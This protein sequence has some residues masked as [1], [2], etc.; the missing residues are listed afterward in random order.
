MLAAI[1]LVRRLGLAI[2]ALIL[3]GNLVALVPGSNRDHVS[4]V[5]L[6]AAILAF[7]LPAVE[8]SSF[9]SKQE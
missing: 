6:G 5:A 2:G 9:G 4:Y 7:F 3:F 8:A 1:R